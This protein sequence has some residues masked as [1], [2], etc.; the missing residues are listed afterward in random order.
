LYARPYFAL[1]KASSAQSTLA[2]VGNKI[3]EPAARCRQP[4]FPAVVGERDAE[5]A[6]ILR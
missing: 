5:F 4:C 6:A 3:T 2:S 1:D